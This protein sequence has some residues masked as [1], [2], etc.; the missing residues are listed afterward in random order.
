MTSDGDG[1]IGGEAL[2]E[3]RLSTLG[4]LAGGVL[5]EIASPL[6][7]LNLTLMRLDD[8]LARDDSASAKQQLD[9]AQAMVGVL[10]DIVRDMRT[11]THGGSELAVVDVAE[12]IRS[13]ARIAEPSLKKRARVELDLKDGITIAAV[14]GLLAQV[15]VNF[16]VNAA[17]AMPP[18][19]QGL[20]RISARVDG[21]HVRIEVADD[22][23]GIPDALLARIFEPFYT[24]KPEGEG[25]GLGLAICQAIVRQHQGEIRAASELG[26]GTTMTV[27]LPHATPAAEASALR[28]QLRTRALLEARRFFRQ[29]VIR[30][31]APLELSAVSQGE[32]VRM[33][34]VLEVLAE[35]PAT[36]GIFYDLITLEPGWNREAFSDN[37]AQLF[38]RMVRELLNAV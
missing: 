14:P 15:I 2:S 17:Q 3:E 38:V 21:A 27:L 9:A 35:D 1:E 26:R 18:A 7:A 11:L 34:R 22:G 25:T 28:E 20:I 10:I 13:A 29:H 33:L 19:K 12:V 5:H 4:L 6:T 8:D 32:I 37:E 23:E 36:C 30:Q 24:S 31:A 16:L